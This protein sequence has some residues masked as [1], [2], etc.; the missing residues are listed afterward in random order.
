MLGRQRHPS[1]QDLLLALDSEL[2]RPKLAR[3]QRHISQCESCCKRVSA[4]ESNLAEVTAFY[5]AEFK[6][7][8]PDPAGPTAMLR[9]RLSESARPTVRNSSRIDGFFLRHIRLVMACSIVLILLA[10][11]W[12]MNRVGVDLG[13]SVFAEAPIEPGAI[14][15]PNLT[16]GATLPLLGNDICNATLH[17]HLVP[18]VPSPL[19]AQVFKEYGIEN[20]VPGAYEVD[21]LITPELGGASDLKNL[22]PEPYFNVVWNARVKD[23]LEERLQSL[24][25]RGDLDLQTA[26]Q[27][28]AT[29]WIEAYKKYFHSTKPIPNPTRVAQNE[30]FPA[31][32]G[33]AALLVRDHPAF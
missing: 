21:Y 3:L 8:I 11:A 9:A 4:V 16:P 26:Q 29:N 10:G 25:C 18:H 23:A 1:D 24:V 27:E 5:E 20:P 22:W 2:A 32:M 28:I 13:N 19:S 17:R 7:D 15:K 30:T 6:T 31:V 14:P 33:L 12:T